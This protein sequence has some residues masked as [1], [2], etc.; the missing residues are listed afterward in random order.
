MGRNNVPNGILYGCKRPAQTC[1][2]ELMLVAGVGPL[3]GFFMRSFGQ[4]SSNPMS[5]GSNM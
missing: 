1:S 5:S 2:G 4:G 3:R